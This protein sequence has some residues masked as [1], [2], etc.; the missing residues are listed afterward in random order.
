MADFYSQLGKNTFMV[1]TIWWY[2][3]VM[4]IIKRDC[5]MQVVE[6]S[7]WTSS[8]NR[9]KRIKGNESILWGLKM[10]KIFNSGDF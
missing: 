3:R 10:D 5:S 2:L 9:W 4:L 6:V 1:T 7:R 8:V